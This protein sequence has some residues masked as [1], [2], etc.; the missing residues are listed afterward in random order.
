[1]LLKTQFILETSRII[2]LYLTFTV[3]QEQLLGRKEGDETLAG[4]TRQR[5]LQMSSY[6]VKESDAEWVVLLAPE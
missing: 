5:Q 4:E 2:S 6:S 3:E 1:M